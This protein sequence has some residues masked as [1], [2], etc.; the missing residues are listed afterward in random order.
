[1]KV[2]EDSH[3]SELT[4]NALGGFPQC[5]YTRKVCGVDSETVARRTELP[6]ILFHKKL[7]QKSG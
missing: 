7:T 6:T 1:M 5:A 4:R 2:A 3:S